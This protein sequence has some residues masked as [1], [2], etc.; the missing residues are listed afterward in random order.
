MTRGQLSVELGSGGPFWLFWPAEEDQILLLS[1]NAAGML[2]MA[3]HCWA[4][5]SHPYHQSTHKMIYRRHLVEGLLKHTMAPM[6]YIRLSPSL[7]EKAC[8]KK[9]FETLNIRLWSINDKS[10]FLLKL[11]AWYFILAKPQSETM[12]LFKRVINR[13][14]IQ[15]I[16]IKCTSPLHWSQSFQ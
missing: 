7:R 11:Q 16:A 12:H 3:L 2:L 6:Y 14:L 8:W 5:C 1:F 9:V 10:C 15:K 4:T 13:N